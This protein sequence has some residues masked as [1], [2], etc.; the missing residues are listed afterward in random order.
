MN[1]K[2]T[3]KGFELTQEQRD[4][5]IGKLEKLDKFQITFHSQDIFIKL[6]HPKTFHF[7]IAVNTSVGA[8]EA[9]ADNKNYHEALSEV[10][11]RLER[12]LIKQKSKPLAS[13]N[14]PRNYQQI[15][16]TEE[17]E[18]TDQAIEEVKENL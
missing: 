5:I 3:A 12:Q 4:F 2:I 16:E 17:L 11:E 7:E 10:F 9:S 8:I 18:E 1:E 15:N 13:R 14:E 6:E